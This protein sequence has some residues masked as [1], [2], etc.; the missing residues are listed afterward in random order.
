MD[1]EEA[2]K[3]HYGIKCKIQESYKIKELIHNVYNHFEA[4]INELENRS[5][6]SCEHCKEVFGYTYPLCI[7]NK[8]NPF[9]IHNSKSLN[10]NKYKAKKGVR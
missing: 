7:E 4:K 8:V 5:C 9:Q 10:C 1:R 3:E 6:E 2:I